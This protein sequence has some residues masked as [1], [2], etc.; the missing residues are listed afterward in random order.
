MAQEAVLQPETPE[1]KDR[2]GAVLTNAVAG[3]L[4]VISATVNNNS[5]QDEN[6]VAMVEARSS[7][8]ITELLEFQIAQASE[9]NSIEFGIS[10]TPEEAG[11]YEL[12]TY[13][14]SGLQ[15]PQVLSEVTT[16][17]ITVEEN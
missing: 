13:L 7:I 12:R 9:N 15:E 11:T 5:T 17:Q 4:S 6:F 2:S 1:L 14:L 3:E 10:W 16:K 8:G